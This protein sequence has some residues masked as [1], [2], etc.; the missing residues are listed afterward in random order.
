VGRLAPYGAVPPARTTAPNRSLF[1]DRNEVPELH[2]SPDTDCMRRFYAEF[3]LPPPMLRSMVTFF[4]PSQMNVPSLSWFID[5]DT[6]LE[7][8]S[9]SLLPRCGN[10]TPHVFLFHWSKSPL[11]SKGGPLFFH[12]DGGP[13]LGT[14]S[15]CSCIIFFFPHPWFSF[16]RKS[17]VVNICSA[18]RLCTPPYTSSVCPFF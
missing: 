7:G 17:L 12:E 16:R 13:C 1:F 15:C 4:L 11:L 8:L 10:L 14:P 5:F 3:P 2:L 6:F 9:S 18:P